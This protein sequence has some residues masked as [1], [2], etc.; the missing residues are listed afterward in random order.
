MPA[1][2]SAF[3]ESLSLEEVKSIHEILLSTYQAD[4]SK[5]ASPAQQKYLKSFFQGSFPLIAEQFK[6]SKVDPHI[7]SR[8]LK[9]ALD[10]LE[11]AGLFKKVQASS[12]SGVPLSAQLKQNRFKLL[13]VDIGLVQH[14]LKLDIEAVYN[15]SLIQINRGAIAEQF[16]GQELLAYRD[17]KTEESLFY[18]EREKVGSAAEVDFLFS[19]N[20]NIIPIE[21]KAGP[22]GRLRSIH[23]FM[24]DKECSIGIHISEKPLSYE[25]GI[26]TVPFYLISQIPTLLQELL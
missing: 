1:A 4:F 5:Y 17:P 18:W 2:V 14:A 6:Y 3:S 21:V 22:T 19:Y 12:A 10:H 7:R 16:V 8:E 15:E 11:W 13:F 9:D 24:K 23:Q 20:S 25:K 26:L